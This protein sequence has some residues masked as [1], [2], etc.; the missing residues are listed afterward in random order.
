MEAAIETAIGVEPCD[1]IA[2]RAVDFRE[3]ATDEH[4]AVRLQ[5]DGCHNA[6]CCAGIKTGVQAPIRVEPGNSGPIRV[7]EGV[8][9][10]ADE[11]LAI[12]LQGERTNNL[13]SSAGGCE[14]AV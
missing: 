6:P 5:R 8:E 9:R 10:P 7:A 2:V 12:R 4:L 11:H 14:R 3:R 13:I 1:A